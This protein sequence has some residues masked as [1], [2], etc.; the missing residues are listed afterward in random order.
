MVDAGQPALSRCVWRSAAGEVGV[1][2]CRRPPY[3]VGLICSPR[4]R[5]PL[6]ALLVPLVARRQNQPAGRALSAVHWYPV[7]VVVLAH[8]RPIHPGDNGGTQRK[9]GND[10]VQRLPY[11]V[12]GARMIL[13]SKFL[14]PLASR[15]SS[16]IS[17]HRAPSSRGARTGDGISWQI[18]V[19][20][21]LFN[22]CRRIS[23]LTRM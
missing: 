7:P 19:R 6:N 21:R 23:Y 1:T 2:E 11:G 17:R 8:N 14:K 3:I 18:T 16:S 9:V 22:T 10:L 5:V 4:L 13:N 15:T 12:R 20:I